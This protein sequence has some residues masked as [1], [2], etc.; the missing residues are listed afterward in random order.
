ML[1]GH[2]PMLGGGPLCHVFMSVLLLFWRWRRTPQTQLSS[3]RIDLWKPWRFSVQQSLLLLCAL[4]TQ[5][6][7]KDAL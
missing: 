6:Q 7:A 4:Q 1:A 2:Q 5:Q 3:R